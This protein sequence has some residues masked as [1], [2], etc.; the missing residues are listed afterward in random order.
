MRS[1]IIN[2]MGQKGIVTIGTQDVEHLLIK[3]EILILSKINEK[4]GPQI[5]SANF[6]P[7]PRLVKQFLEGHLLNEINKRNWFEKIKLLRSKLEKLHRKGIIHGDIKA[8]NI[9]C[10]DQDVKLI[11]WQ[12]AM[13]IGERV[14]KLAFRPCSLGSTHPDL[15]W[16]RGIVTERFDHYSLN[17]LI[18][19][20]KS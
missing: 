14:E 10:T 9:I 1:R 20:A 18:N 11:D 6:D 5:L 7:K 4:L 19:D 15:I 13:R 17:S 3:N 16:G 8:S 2:Y 12:C